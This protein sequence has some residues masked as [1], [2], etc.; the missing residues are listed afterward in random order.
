MTGR[1]RPVFQDV[2]SL[3]SDYVRRHGLDSRSVGWRD[4]ATHRLR[5]DK[6][7]QGLVPDASSEPFTVNDL[8]SGYGAMFRYLDQR[9]GKRLAHYRGYEI[10]DAMIEASRAFVA[11]DDRVE[12]IKAE[13]PQQ[14]ADYSFVCGTFNVKL[15]TSDADWDALVKDMI[16]RVAEQSTRGFAF[17]LLTSYVDWKEPHLFYADPTHYFDFC[18]RNVS[19]TVALLHD[20]PLFEWTIIVTK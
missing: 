9:F 5:F 16:L 20:Y 4:E 7:V 13:V 3:Y 1:D 8:G 18:K 17:N 15:Q 10:S 12:I 19:S 6:L 14:S 2:E 11:N